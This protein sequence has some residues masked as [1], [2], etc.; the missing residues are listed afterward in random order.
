MA[1]IVSV[2]ILFHLPAASAFAQQTGPDVISGRVTDDS[3]H[4]L[5]AKIMVTRGPDRLK[6]DATTDSAGNF[7]VRFE[8]GTGDYLVYVTATGFASARRRVQTQNGEHDLIANFVLPRAVVA[9]LDAVKVP[10]QKPVRANNPI[11]PT[12]PETGAA[13]KW[14]DGVNGQIPP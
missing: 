8:E 10:G 7:R 4:A 14:R 11:G 2:A 6:Q 5:V 9:T 13:E 12:Q 1:K 3:S